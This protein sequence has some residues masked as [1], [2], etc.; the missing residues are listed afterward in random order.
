MCGHKKWKAQFWIGKRHKRI[1]AP[2]PLASVLESAGLFSLFPV[3]PFILSTDG[4][5]YRLKKKCQRTTS[6][7]FTK[8]IL[9]KSDMEKTQKCMKKPIVF[10]KRTPTVCMKSSVSAPAFLFDFCSLFWCLFPGPSVDKLNGKRNVAQDFGNR[11]LH[12]RWRMCSSVFY[13][14]VPAHIM[15][16]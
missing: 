12:R 7:A 6:P 13:K 10:V 11:N 2:A 14:S 9:K 5:P 4:W 1:K 16:M 8:C 15:K 3:F